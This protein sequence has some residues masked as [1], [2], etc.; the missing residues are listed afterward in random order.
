MR[1]FVAIELPKEVKEELFRIQSLIKP[2]VA[3]IK[4]VSKKNL[5]L[6]LKFIG[7]TKVKSEEIIKLLKKVEFKPIK[8]K[9]SKFGVFPSWDKIYVFWV[10]IEPKE[11]VIEMQQKV[12]SELLGLFNKDQKFVP[13]LTL[14][15]VKLVKHKKE[16]V[17]IL[18]AVSVKPIEFE[19][20]EFKLMESKLTKDGP[21]YSEVETFRK[22]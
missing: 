22:I 17:D 10:D 12:D 18:K 21:I 14:G 20:N 4:W 15:R 7:E 11:E 3:K 5:H 1:L 16:F 6:T 19:I 2:G 8:C 9:L 13:H